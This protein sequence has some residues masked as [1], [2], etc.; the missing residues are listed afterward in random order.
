MQK[1]TPIERL[2]KRRKL[3][4]GIII[5][6]GLL[7]IF[8]FFA[9]NSQ[10]FHIKQINI[11]NN[12][13][14]NKE[15]IIKQSKVTGNTNIFKFKISDIESNLK[16]NQFIKTAIV[17]RKLPSTLNINIVEREKI[18]LFQYI[19]MYLVIDKEGFIIE[20]LDSN[21]KK[22]PT[23]TGFN[24][25]FTEINESIFSKEEN[26]N[27]SIF[28]NDAK[29]LHLL[30]KMDTIDKDFSNDINIKLKNGIFVAFGTLNNVKYK[31]D[32]LK[33]ILDDVEAKEIKADKIIMN[34]GS[35][36]I[37]IMKD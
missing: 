9:L 7:S 10:F 23:V 25:N 22:L 8:T 5:F 17:K 32:L 33:E 13:T 16:T 30:S 3:F 27:L 4:F 1:K 19:S 20:H 31:L 36:P 18:V 21:D 34:R 29:S 37:L 14:L 28:I 24:T 26:K 2:H 12:K 11:K 15:D 35:H 6:L